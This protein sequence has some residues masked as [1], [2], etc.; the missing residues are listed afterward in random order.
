[1]TATAIHSWNAYREAMRLYD[2]IPE[3]TS[4]PWTVARH[5]V[6]EDEAKRDAFSA[7]MHGSRRRVPPGVYTGLLRNGQIWMSD[8]PDEMSDHASAYNEARKRGGR[9]LIHGLGLGMVTQAL[10]SL[11]NVEHVDVVELDED[12]IKLVAPAFQDEIDAGRLT[13]HHDNCLTKQWDKKLHWQGVWSDIWRDLCTDNLSEMATL[14]RKFG[15]KSDWH[16]CWC[17]ELLLYHRHQ[18]RRSGW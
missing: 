1:M 2:R 16:E 8:T 17:R 15:R 5:T 6:T 11:E 4:G 12:V 3:G 14:R 10:L 13:I 18:E 7:T 9:W